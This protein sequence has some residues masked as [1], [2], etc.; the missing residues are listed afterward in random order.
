ML[1]SPLRAIARRSRL[2]KP[3]ISQSFQ[4]VPASAA[5]NGLEGTMPIP[6]GGLE[7]TMPVNPSNNSYNNNS[8]IVQQQMAARN[9]GQLNQPMTMADNFLNTINQHSQGASIL[10][11]RIPQAP[12]DP[13]QKLNFRM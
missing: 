11:Q 13:K 3:G 9:A 2:L 10:N 8:A 7:G 1:A 6:Q 4:S 12:N 5:G